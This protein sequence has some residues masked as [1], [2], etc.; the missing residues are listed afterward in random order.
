MECRVRRTFVE[1]SKVL[2]GLNRC[3]KL[4]RKGLNAIAILLRFGQF[5]AQRR[6]HILID[7]GVVH[8]VQQ[9]PGE[10]LLGLESGLGRGSVLI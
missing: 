5:A 9:R 7:V 4:A 10:G 3:A 1:V 6:F 2:R 8:R